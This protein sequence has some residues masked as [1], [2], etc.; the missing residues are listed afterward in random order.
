MLGAACPSGKSW[1]QSW[2]VRLKRGREADI[3]PEKEPG[4]LAMETMFWVCAGVTQIS[5]ILGVAFAAE[6]AFRGERT[7]RTNGLY[8]LARSVA[9]LLL[10]AAALA[11]GSPELVIVS[12]AVMLVVQGIDGLIGVSLRSRRRTLGPFF[13]AVCHSLCLLALR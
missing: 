12:A 6:A 9:L 5:A 7:G 10:A 8:T 1:G 4:E 2:A 11:M 3:I 13:L